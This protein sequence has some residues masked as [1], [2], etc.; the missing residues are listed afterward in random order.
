MPLKHAVPVALK[1]PPFTAAEASG[2]GVTRGQLRGPS[3]R[4]MGSGFY[5]WVG[6]K[7]SPQLIL[8]A[9]AGR[10]PDGAAF[11][12][13]TAAWLHGL[14]L[15]PCDPIEVT[16]PGPIVAAAVPVH[17]FGEPPSPAT[18]SCS[19]MV[20]PRHQHSVLWPTSAAEI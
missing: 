17:P 8:A 1:T 9:V 7:E 11:S 18:R 3:Y 4:R 19:D 12:G 6:L 20:Y 15:A 2:L 10:L 5:R 13:R 14:D 16:I